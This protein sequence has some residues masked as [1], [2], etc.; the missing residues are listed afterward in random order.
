LQTKM[1]KMSVSWVRI[2]LHGFR[3]FV[4]EDAIRHYNNVINEIIT[5]NVTLILLDERVNFILE[6][7]QNYVKCWVTINEVN[8][9]AYADRNMRTATINQFGITDYHCG[10]HALLVYAKVCNVYNENF[11]HQ[12]IFCSKSDYYFKLIKNRITALAFIKLLKQLNN[13]YMLPEVYIT[14]NAYADIGKISNNG[15]IVD[16]NLQFFTIYAKS[17]CD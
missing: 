9:M 1:F 7:F 15:E 8:L 4:N 6:Q 14:E 16:V 2:L 11:D 13:H 12:S 10:Y 5:N 17:F 3:N